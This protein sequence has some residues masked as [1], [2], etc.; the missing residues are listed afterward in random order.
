MSTVQIENDSHMVDDDCE[1]EEEMGNA[2]VLVAELETVG[3]SSSDV[4]KL[5]TAGYHTAQAVAMATIRHLSR[6]KG[7]SEEKAKKIQD[8]A[9]KL[10]PM[11]FTT[12]QAHNNERQSVVHIGTG[13]KALDQLLQGGFETGC[14]TEM[15]GE[16]R[17][18]KTQLCHTLCVTCQ[19]PFEQGGGQGKALFIDTEGTFRPNRLISIAER[20]GMTP[21]DV[22]ENVSYARAYN[23]EHQSKLLS[24]A[25]QMMT[26]TRYALLIVDSATALFRSDY[27]GRG[28][29]SERQI[30]LGQFLR[31]LMR[32]ADQFK[33][34]VV[35]TNQV[36]ADCGGMSM[37]GDPKKPIGGN[38]MAHASTV[39]LYLKK[40]RGNARV[41]KIY[42]SPNLPE[43]D[44]Q[45]AI[46]ESGIV[47]VDD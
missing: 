18:G 9:K 15:F 32:L 43:S 22:L 34:A 10:V 23:S 3:V 36:V 12:A 19:L 45:F 2:V 47:D 24:Q 1:E 8:C 38:I 42:D 41:C 6:V 20:Y 27:V 14:I 35:I 30:A 13:S 17:T 29:L 46:S 21:N 28:E 31:E 40:G 7:I 26:E 25:A 44:C 37:F 5:S 11:G 39:R 4:K 33:V 16:F